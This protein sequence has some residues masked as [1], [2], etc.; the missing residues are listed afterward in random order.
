MPQTITI[1]PSNIKQEEV[2]TDLTGVTELTA[3]GASIDYANPSKILITVRCKELNR[4]LSK[5][6]FNN[7]ARI[8][9]ITSSTASF[10]SKIDTLVSEAIAANDYA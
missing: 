4:P 2:I 5:V 10:T 6:L 9:E 8:A 1:P 7:Q 3:T